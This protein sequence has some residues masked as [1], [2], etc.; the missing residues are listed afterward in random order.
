MLRS[1]EHLWRLAHAQDTRLGGSPSFLAQSS[2]CR[3]TGNTRGPSRAWSVR[4]CGAPRRSVRDAQLERQAKAPS[5][6]QLVTCSVASSAHC[7]APTEPSLPLRHQVPL[8]TKGPGLGREKNLRILRSSAP[9][10][11]LARAQDT[12]LG[13]S[14]SFLAQSSLCGRTGNTRG[15]SRA[16]SLRQCGAPCRSVRHAQLECQVKA[17]SRDQ[18]V[19]RSVASTARCTAPHRGIV[20]VT[21]FA[22][23][24]APRDLALASS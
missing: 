14:P 3:R 16:W 22:R 17:P 1:G 19:T 24:A 13:G 4:Q 21:S 15:P 5:R 20:P 7:A 9:L 11:R 10:W 2:L 8:S 18:L 23:C 6:D 12:W